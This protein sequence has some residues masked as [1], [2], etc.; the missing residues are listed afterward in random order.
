MHIYIY[1]H[2]HMHIY[3]VYTY[4][5]PYKYPHLQKIYTQY[6]RDIHTLGNA[7]SWTA[8]SL[9]YFRNALF[10]RSSDLKERVLEE[11]ATCWLQLE[12][13]Y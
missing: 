4:I 12:S 3:I 13:F 10:Y 1:I 2:I 9:Y 7:R 8:F 6:Y 5:Y 11:A